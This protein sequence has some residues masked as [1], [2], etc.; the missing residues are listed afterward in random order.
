MNGEG[1]HTSHFA[2]DTPVHAYCPSGGSFHS[3][4]GSHLDSN[5]R[6]AEEGGLWRA[7]G[8]A[9]TRAPLP[10]VAHTHPTW[11]SLLPGCQMF[12]DV[13]RTSSFGKITLS[14]ELISLPPTFFDVLYMLTGAARIKT[15]PSPN[16][17]PERGGWCGTNLQA[18]SL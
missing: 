12:I 3:Q 4:N 11:P 10:S 16:T 9:N 7:Q 5:P 1:D 6:V 18:S 15:R 17:T 2:Q 14:N 8:P 13:S